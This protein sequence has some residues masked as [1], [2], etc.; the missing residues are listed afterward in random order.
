MVEVRVSSGQNLAALGS[1]QP[2]RST[3]AR[4]IGAIA[5]VRSLMSAVVGQVAA[6]VDAIRC[7]SVGPGGRSRDLP[8]AVLAVCPG[9]ESRVICFAADGEQGRRAEGYIALSMS[10]EEEVR[11]FGGF[12][13]SGHRPTPVCN[14]TLP[15]DGLTDE[16]LGQALM[17]IHAKVSDAVQRL[18]MEKAPDKSI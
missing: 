9:A 17:D 13:D 16:K 4:Q 8:M 3:Q 14:K 10:D 11:T 5:P 15:L 6:M 12:Y 7:D 1:E 18:L 2:G